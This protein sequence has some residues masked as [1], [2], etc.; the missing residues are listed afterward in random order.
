MKISP[1]GKPGE[2]KVAETKANG[3]E[4]LNKA[5]L[6]YSRA[7][8]GGH[9]TV[10]WPAAL[11]GEMAPGNRSRA[12]SHGASIFTQRCKQCHRAVSPK[13]AAKACQMPPSPES[14]P[15]LTVAKST[16]LE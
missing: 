12:Y 11:G 3:Q 5:P 2:S 8:Q 10:M 15:G 4:N 7:S 1:D 13:T 9:A 16:S 6:R 14:S